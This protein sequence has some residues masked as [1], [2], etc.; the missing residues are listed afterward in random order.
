L[1]GQERGGVDVWVMDPELP[2]TREHHL[3]GIS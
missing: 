1:N 2:V 3:L